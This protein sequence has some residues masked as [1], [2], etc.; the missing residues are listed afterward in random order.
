MLVVTSVGH[1][2]PWLFEKERNMDEMSAYL[3]WAIGAVFIGV[4][5]YVSIVRDRKGK[6]M[7]PK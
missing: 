2:L 5:A 4:V 7:A 6:S 1:N 3:A